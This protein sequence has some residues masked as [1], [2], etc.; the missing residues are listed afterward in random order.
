MAGKGYTGESDGD[1]A[2][3]KMERILKKTSH[4]SNNVKTLKEQLDEYE[5]KSFSKVY[6]SYGV[7]SREV[8]KIFFDRYHFS[9]SLGFCADRF[10]TNPKVVLKQLF[11]DE[12]MPTV[13]AKE[14][15]KHC[16]WA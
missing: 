3:D 11:A 7:W 8:E 9:L 12:I 5:N 6:D 2:I 14:L 1:R 13:A 10:T 16:V 4:E 15:A